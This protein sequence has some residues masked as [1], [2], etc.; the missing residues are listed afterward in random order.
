MTVAS[1]ARCLGLSMEAELD[2][3]TALLLGKM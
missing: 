3:V 2:P 1:L